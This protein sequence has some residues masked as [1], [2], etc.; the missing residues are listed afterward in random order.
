M[1]SLERILTALSHKEP[2]RVPFFLPVTMHPAR[3]LGLSIRDYFS[4]ARHVVEG[5]LLY[6]ERIGH[7]A[8]YGFFHAP[9][10]LIPWGG[11]VVYREDGPPNSGAPI[12][13]S[14]EEITG[15]K[16]PE[17]ASCRE[18]QEVLSAIEML[19]D[20]ARGEVPVFGVVMSPFSLPVM[21]MGFGPYLDLMIGRR[22]LFL[23]LME[24]NRRFCLE[25]ARAQLEAGATGI[26]YFDPVA[27]PE[28]IPRKLYQE[29]ALPLA[30]ELISE[31]PGP[32]V[33]HFA[34]GRSLSIL[35][36]VISCGPVAVGVS[37]TE[38]LLQLKQAAGSRVTLLG[39]LNGVEMRRWT[40]SEVARNVS[41]AMNVGGPG[42]GFILADS[43]GEIPLQVPVET[44]V[45]IG[46]VVREQ[47][48]YPLKR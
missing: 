34:S 43:H 24:L 4:R 11:E 2:D 18:L 17:V 40:R 15:L 38:S 20:Q 42:G 29:L 47:G 8:L 23:H 45:E 30:R 19:K 28:M 13:G 39:N 48:I 41:A 6:R 27:S 37:G 31:I 36:E 12:I 35:D 16:C 14:P 26:V 46:R 5:Q 1:T 22:E 21:Q 33:V 32:V 7:D 44:L 10:E 3:D 25:W 9:A